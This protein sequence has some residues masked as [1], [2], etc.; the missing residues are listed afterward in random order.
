[1]TWLIPLSSAKSTEVNGY[2]GKIYLAKSMS[3]QE[4]LTGLRTS[5]IKQRS[6]LQ[7]FK[8]SSDPFFGLSLG[9]LNLTK[10]LS[11][12]CPSAHSNFVRRHVHTN[13]ESDKNNVPLRAT[14]IIQRAYLYSIN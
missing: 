13:N 2:E 6:V 7:L 3:S 4:L 12:G 9:N 5:Y 10:L 1:M 14:E 8:S 11:A